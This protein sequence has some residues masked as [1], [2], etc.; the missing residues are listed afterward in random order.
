ML[1][2]RG[3]VA[4]NKDNIVSAAVTSTKMP[5]NGSIGIEE[6]QLLGEWLACGAP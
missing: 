2:T 3:A 6:R 5:A 1:T 4:A